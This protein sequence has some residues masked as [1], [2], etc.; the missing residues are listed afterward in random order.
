MKKSILL[1][2]AV[3]LPILLSA[4]VN[5]QAIERAD[6]DQ[7]V[8]EFYALVGNVNEVRFKSYIGP[9]MAVG[10]L[11]GVL[12]NI[13]ADSDAMIGGAIV[14]ALFGG[15]L[16]AIFEGSSS[17]YEYQLEAIDGDLVTVIVGDKPASRG[18]C[19]NV[20]VSGSVRISKQPMF[21]C[22]TESEF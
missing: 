9:A 13:H 12:N 3:S 11:D 17:G 22:E 6:R 1:L 21:Y 14:G 8:T 20:R 15:I 19:V 7:F 18:E 2:G 5:S 4:C 16:A 10:A